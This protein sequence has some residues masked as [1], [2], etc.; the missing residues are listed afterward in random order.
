MACRFRL[1]ACCSLAVAAIAADA[2]TR[3][4]EPA[5]LKVLFLGDQG[6]HQPAARFRQLRPVMAERR[7]ELTYTENLGDLNTKTLGGYAGLLL[8][9]NIDRIEPDQAKALLDYV[10]GGHGF[11]PI[12]CAS[13]CF[14]N[15]D[16]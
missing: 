11:M 13:Y 2:T 6:H 4:A 8:Y 14:R 16:E 9:A 3:G 15:N 1:V 10:A 5:P 7:I 12:H